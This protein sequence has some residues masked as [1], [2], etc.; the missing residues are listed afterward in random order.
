MIGSDLEELLGFRGFSDLF[1]FRNSLTLYGR[2]P[3]GG[4]DV[5]KTWGNRPAVKSRREAQARA[6]RER[7]SA[8][9]QAMR[10]A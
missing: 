7:D 1:V 2:N 5:K 8:K 9:P 10:A 3:E 6:E 4:P